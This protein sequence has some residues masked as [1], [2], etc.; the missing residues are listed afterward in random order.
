MSRR[1]INGSAYCGILIC[2]EV[3][4]DDVSRK[5]VFGK[6]LSRLSNDWN[7]YVKDGD[8]T[9]QYVYGEKQIVSA[10]MSI[11]GMS[12]YGNTIRYHIHQRSSV[13][14]QGGV[15]QLRATPHF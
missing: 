12:L 11:S 1:V 5:V 2:F 8:H 7:N 15:T 6:V 10:I 4:F 9:P 13:I 3:T 14:E